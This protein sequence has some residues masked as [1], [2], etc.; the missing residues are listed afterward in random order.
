MATS[1]RGCLK[2]GCV[3]CV[4]LLALTLVVVGAL[5]VL[6]LAEGH[7]EERV[8]QVSRTVVLPELPAD[9]APPVLPDRRPLAEAPGTRQAGR[10]VLD[11]SRTDLTVRPA[12]AGSGLGLEGSYDAAAFELEERYDADGGM[13]WAYHLRFEPRGLGLRFVAGGQNNRLR[14]TVPRDTPLSIEGSIGAGRS[15]LELGGLW[16]VALD[17]QLGAG[18]HEIGFAEPL[19]FAAEGFRVRSGVGELAVSGLGNASP[20][21]VQ[22]RH[23]IGQVSVDLEGAWVCDA[24]VDV[25]C[26]VGDCRLRVPRNVALELEDIDVMTGE[27]VTPR[28]EATPAEEVPL[29]TLRLSVRGKV[30]QVRVSR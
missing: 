7:P 6:V 14:L 1:A 15:D 30:G 3:G 12:P 29:P 16:L 24:E 13:R 20:A 21:S 27:V 18:R 17:L 4:V 2:I 9:A 5:I 19:P 22:I 8:E 11:L 28:A 25:R 10:I 23:R 26:G